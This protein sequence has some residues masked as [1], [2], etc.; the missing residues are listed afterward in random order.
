MPGIQLKT[1]HLLISADIAAAVFGEAAQT[2]TVYYPQQKALLLAPMDD[3]IFPQV[4]KAQL[5]MLKNRNLQGD[6]SI[7]L[8]EIII[9][10]ELDETDR[11]LAYVF[12]PGMRMLKITL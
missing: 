5:Q 6:R 9:D 8:Q 7:S 4:H 12:E 1:Q 2:Y 11:D 3:D 10:H